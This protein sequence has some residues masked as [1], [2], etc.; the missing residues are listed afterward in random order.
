MNENR[1][2]GFTNR[3]RFFP[4]YVVI[5]YVNNNQVFARWPSGDSTR[6]RN[7]EEDCLRR[8]SLISVK[9]KSTLSDEDIAFAISEEEIYI[10]PLKKILERIQILLDSGRFENNADT[11]KILEEVLAAK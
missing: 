3:S 2:I 1:I 11:K 5:L 4:M 9:D 7:T 6:I 10:E 8:P